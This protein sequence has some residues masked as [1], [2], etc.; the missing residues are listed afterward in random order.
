TQTVVHLDDRLREEIRD[1]NAFYDTSCLVL[2]DKLPSNGCRRSDDCMS[3]ESESIA[4]A[5][6]QSDDKTKCHINDQSKDVIIGDIVGVS[7]GVSDPM[8]TNGLKIA[9]NKC[10]DKVDD[11]CAKSERKYV[12]DY[13]SCDKSYTDISHLKRHQLIHSGRVYRCGCDG[14]SA[15]F[16]SPQYLDRHV[17]RQHPKYQC[18][19]KTGIITPRGHQQ[20]KAKTNDKGM[21][22]VVKPFTTKPTESRSQ[23]KVSEECDWSDEDMDDNS[24]PKG[25]ASVSKYRKVDGK[26]ICDINSCHKKYADRRSLREHQMSHSGKRFYCYIENCCKHFAHK[27]SLRIHLKTG[28][29]V[30]GQPFACVYECGFYINDRKGLEEHIMSCPSTELQVKPTTD[31]TVNTMFDKSVPQKTHHSVDISLPMNST[32]EVMDSKD[33]DYFDFDMGFDMNGDNDSS[34]DE[35]PIANRIS[36]K[37]SDKLSTNEQKVSE[38]SGGQHSLRCDF[39]GC[40]A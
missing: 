24:E 32:S 1:L 33:E 39:E 3:S 17:K 31:Q 10:L 4:D 12:C 6:F 5:L 36:D 7:G 16:T 23:K 21:E 26:Y 30:F 13:M 40:S 35:E 14:C 15:T 11:S 20:M 27:S 25:S 29:H 38:L 2:V 37:T 28:N 22:E 18:D 8:A 19:Y 9:D 34:A